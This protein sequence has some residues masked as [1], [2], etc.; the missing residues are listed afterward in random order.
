MQSHFDSISIIELTPNNQHP[1]RKSHLSCKLPTY[2]NNVPPIEGRTI[3]RVSITTKAPEALKI[4]INWKRYTTHPWP[5][6]GG[7]SIYPHQL[8]LYFV[9]SIVHNIIKRKAISPL[10][11]IHESSLSMLYPIQSDLSI[12]FTHSHFQWLPFRCY[13]YSS[14]SSPFS[15]TI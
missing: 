5:E 9:G 4:H 10:H 14:Y 2:K 11:I 13:S 12:Q 15:P 7:K 6:P 1:F 8:V 3:S